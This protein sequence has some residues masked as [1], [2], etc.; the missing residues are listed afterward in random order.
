MHHAIS[1]SSTTFLLLDFVDCSRSSDLMIVLPFILGSRSAICG[2]TTTIVTFA[3]Q[4]HNS[5]SLEAVL[6]ETHGKATGN[7]YCDYGFHLI[8]SNTSR[9]TLNSFPHLIEQEGVS[10]LKI[11]MTY[12]A[13]QLGD[14]QI[15]DVLLAARQNGLTTMIHAENGDVLE[16]MTNKL[17]EKGLYAP[18][19]HAMSRP[20]ILETEATNRAITLSEIIS[21]PILIVHVS[22]PSAAAH[23]RNGQTRGLPVYAETCPQY[24]FLTRDH[25]NKPGFEGAK[26]VCSPPPRESKEDHQ[27]IWKGLRNGTFTVLSSD[28]CPFLYDDAETGKKSSVTAE[29]PHGQFKHIPNG[30]PGLETRLPLVVSR[31]QEEQLSLPKFVEL[32]ATNPAKLYGLYPRKG[33]LLPGL[34]DADLVIWYPAEHQTVRD[35]TI[36]NDKL[37]HA[38]DHTPFEGI[39]V[40]NWP[41]WTVLRGKVIWDRDGGGVVGE[42]GFGEFVRRGKS[43][44]GWWSEGEWNV[45]AF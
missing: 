27:A 1:F 7:C 43:T 12:A 38:C 39:E 13:L 22:S 19:Y 36:R 34:S 35:L 31:A 4:S 8:V 23:I 2:G 5:T 17:E 3:P 40:G 6:K 44:I 42:K 26:C 10:S 29:Y 25:L 45:E 41:R 18:K 33:A 9:D 28:H 32:T 24:L 21:T 11:Y 30:L 37:H 20:Q 14:K 16:W 15:L